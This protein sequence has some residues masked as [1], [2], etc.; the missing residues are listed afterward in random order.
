[1]NLSLR[2][3]SIASH[4]VTSPLANRVELLASDIG[5]LRRHLGGADRPGADYAAFLL[6]RLA[7]HVRVLDAM[8]RPTAGER[9]RDG[10]GVADALAAVD[11][12]AAELRRALGAE[13]P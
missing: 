5:Q 3:C 6:D 9:H 1:V 12:D 10:L 13:E 8:V 4:G 7:L 11:E 2:E